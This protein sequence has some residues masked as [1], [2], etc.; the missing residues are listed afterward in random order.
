MTEAEAKV[1]AKVVAKPT[2]SGDVLAALT[3]EAAA[4]FARRLTKL[5][6]VSIQLRHLY[7]EHATCLI[8]EKQHKADIYLT[9]DARSHG[10][11]EGQASAMSVSLSTETLLLKGQIS[12]LE[13][14]ASFLRFAIEQDGGA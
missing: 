3:S 7:R 13:E 9:S 4:L 12:A 8:S 10:E 11:R 5:E 6:Q 2:S 14:E 1:K